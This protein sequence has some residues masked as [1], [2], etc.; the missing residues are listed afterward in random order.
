MFD[1]LPAVCR[2]LRADLVQI[3]WLLLIPYVVFILCLELLKIPDGNP[4]PSRVLKRVLISMLLLF[5]FD[6]CMNVIAMI[7]DG[8]T[9]KIN[10]IAQLKDLLNHLADSYKEKDVNWFK[11]REAIIYFISLLSYIIAYLGVFVADVLIHFV[12]SILYVV[13]PLMILMYVSEKTSFVTSNL[14]KG[15]INVVTWK[16][17]WSILGVMLLKL[18]TNPQAATGDNFITSVLMNLC[19]G[20]SMLFIPMAT[21]SL[22]ND[23]LGSAASALAAAPTA[24]AFGAAKLYAQKMGKGG[25]KE[26]FSGFKGTR[27]FAKESYSKVRS[28]IQ[29]GRN[30]ASRSREKIESGLE[31]TKQFGIKNDVKPSQSPFDQKSPFGKNRNGIH[32][33]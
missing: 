28:G 5:S 16:V 4:N 18:A 9:E 2:E 22:I 3:Y 25:I 31:K 8:I 6:E 7:S 29:T 24:A 17:F 33:K 11:F 1:W 21:K 23:G 15:L 30:L 14:Y 27:S 32:P 20:L 19:I 13:S 26:V 10:G 12:W